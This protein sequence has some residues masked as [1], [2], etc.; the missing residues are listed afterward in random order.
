MHVLKPGSAQCLRWLACVF[1]GP[2]TAG[3][4]HAELKKEMGLEH[5]SGDYNHRKQEHNCLEYTDSR[6]CMTRERQEDRGEGDGRRDFLA[7]HQK[8]RWQHFLNILSSVY[9]SHEGKTVKC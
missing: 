2:T 5:V 4:V 3:T 1:Y 7:K 9:S 6:K 8:L